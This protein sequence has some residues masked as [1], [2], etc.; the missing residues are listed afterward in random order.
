MGENE[1][2]AGPAA[3]D[4]QRK[5]KGAIR[6]MLVD[7]EEAYVHVLANRLEKRG[8]QVAKA[9]SGSEAL[10]KMRHY[11]FDVAVLDLKM[12]DMDGIE[13]LKIIKLMDSQMQVIMLTG[14][15]SATA[16]KQGLEFGAFDYIMKPCEL[17][18]LI[19]KIREAFRKKQHLVG[20]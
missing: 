20:S 1:K 2:Q 7:D 19:N 11:E 16:C 6:V 13:V 15:G 3:D 12:T 18:A 17:D 9:Y 5:K 4:S 10:Q 14:H 8:F